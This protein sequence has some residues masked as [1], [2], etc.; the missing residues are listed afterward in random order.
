VEEA[1]MSQAHSKLEKIKLRLEIFALGV[2][3]LVG[4]G[5]SVVGLIAW[6]ESRNANRLNVD[7]QQD[8]D[9]AK[10]NEFLQADPFISGLWAEFPNDTNV[11]FVAHEQISLLV[12]TNDKEFSILRTNGNNSFQWKTVQDLN[13]NLWS[14]DG[15]YDEKRIRLRKAYNVMDWIYD[16]IEYS[17]DAHKKGQLNQEDFQGW[18][19]YLDGLCTHPLFLA[20]PQ[21]DHDNGFVSKEYCSFVLQR[22]LVQPQGRELLSLVYSNMLDPSW[23]NSI[24]SISRH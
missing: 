4:I 10:L 23:T 6:N 11:E 12:S 21:D 2:G 16:Q 24:N 5:G 19:G 13:S 18:I 9:E 14:G 22:I 17:F 15:F 20:S 1:S 7:T 8:A 3:I